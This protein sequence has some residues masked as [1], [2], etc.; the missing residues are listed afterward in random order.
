MMRRVVVT[1]IFKVRAIS[2]AL[3]PSGCCASSF[4]IRQAFRR[5]GMT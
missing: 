5:L 2:A 3:S 4:M 1:G